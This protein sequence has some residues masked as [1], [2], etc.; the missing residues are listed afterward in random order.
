M[1]RRHV[2]VIFMTLWVIMPISMISVLPNVDAVLTPHPIDGPEFDQFTVFINSSAQG[3]INFTAAEFMALPNV[4]GWATPQGDVRAK[5]K[6]VN[7][8]WFATTYGEWGNLSVQFI[9]SDGFTGIMDNT[10]IISNASYCH[11]LAYEYEDRLMTSQYQLWV[12]PVC[13]DSGGDIEFVGRNHP[14]LINEIQIIGGGIAE[15]IIRRAILLVIVFS[16]GVAALGAS[17]IGVSVVIE[18]RKVKQT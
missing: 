7:F 9:A 16:S 14:R 1:N 6:G 13:V 4:T 17:I 2:F 5:F 12:V 10:S 11:I 18:R 3:Q 8:T 15:D